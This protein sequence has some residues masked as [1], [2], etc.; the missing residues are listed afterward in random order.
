MGAQTAADNA[1][2][3]ESEARDD[4]D[5]TSDAVKRIRVRANLSEID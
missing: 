3:S 5:I 4:C 2:N 1:I